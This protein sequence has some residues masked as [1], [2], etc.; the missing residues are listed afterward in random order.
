MGLVR[1][2]LGFIVGTAFGIY[3]AQNYK[4]P[5]VKELASNAISKANELEQAY[6]KRNNKTKDDDGDA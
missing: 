6:R 1:N 3:L 4:V 5:S 2:N